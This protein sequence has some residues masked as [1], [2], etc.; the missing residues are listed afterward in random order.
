M[1][2][3]PLKVTIASSTERFWWG[4]YSSQ[5]AFTTALNFEQ[6]VMIRLTS[7]YDIVIVVK[8]KVLCQ[9]IELMYMGTTLFMNATPRVSFLDYM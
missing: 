2:N 4:G 6:F 8:M 1:L 5:E 3:C 9:F 7:E